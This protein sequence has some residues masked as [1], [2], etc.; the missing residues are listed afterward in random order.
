MYYVQPLFHLYFWQVSLSFKESWRYSVEFINHKDLARGNSP[1]TAPPDNPYRVI[2]QFGHWGP[3][4]YR[5]FPKSKFPLRGILIACCVWLQ[6]VRRRRYSTRNS[7]WNSAGQ[8]CPEMVD[9]GE[10]SCGLCCWACSTGLLLHLMTCQEFSY[11]SYRL[12]HL[13]S[14][15]AR[16]G[17]QWGH[18][19]R[20]Y[21]GYA[22]ILYLKLMCLQTQSYRVPVRQVDSTDVCWKVNLTIAIHL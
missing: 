22:V 19:N 7:C 18:A 6:P 10:Q 11:N 16:A 5:A 8:T 4:L 3:D 17:C 12:I 9:E 15:I 2:W 21:R 13:S 14:S 20:K 1:H